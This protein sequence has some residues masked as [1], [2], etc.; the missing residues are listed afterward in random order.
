MYSLGFQPVKR[1]SRAQAGLFTLLLRERLNSVYGQG[2]GKAAT[3]AML[4]FAA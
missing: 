2:H 4:L 1:Q 3:A